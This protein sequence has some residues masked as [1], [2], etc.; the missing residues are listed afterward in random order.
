MG[1]YEPKIIDEAV[2]Y[3]CRQLISG[4]CRGKRSG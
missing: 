3:I 2:Y 4:P 1:H